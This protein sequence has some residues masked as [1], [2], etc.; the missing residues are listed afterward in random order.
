MERIFLLAP[1]AS[2]YET[3]YPRKD[4]AL[5]AQETVTD[6]QQAPLPN[7]QWVVEVSNRFNNG[8]A[9]LQRG[10]VEL[11]HRSHERHSSLTVYVLN[12][13]VSKAMCY[14][15]KITDPQ[16][17]ISFS[18]LGVAIILTVGGFII[19]TSLVLDTVVGWLQ[20]RFKKGEYARLNWILDDKLQLQRLVS[21]FSAVFVR[22]AC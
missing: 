20:S 22:N 14:S 9:R 5:R 1:F 8:L 19:A 13:V 11:C 17:T 7:D 10:I 12:D 16:G 6:L 18:V 15:Q 2:I 4:A 21:S 3:V